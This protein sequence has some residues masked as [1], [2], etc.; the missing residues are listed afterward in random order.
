[1]SKSTKVS[2]RHDVQ[3]S[4]SQRSMSNVKIYKRSVHFALVLAV[5]EIF[6]FIIF[7]IQK[8]FQGHGVQFL[9]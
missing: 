1:M 5:S 6:Y 9:S 8:V 2:Q 7:D 3:F 4:H